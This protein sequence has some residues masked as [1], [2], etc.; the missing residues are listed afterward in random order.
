MLHITSLVLIFTTES[1]YLAPTFIQFPFPQCPTE[2]FWNHAPKGV[3]Y[4]SPIAETTQM[5]INRT[6]HKPAAM[7][8]CIHRKRTLSNKKEQTTYL[9]YNK[10][11]KHANTKEE[12]ERVHRMVLFIRSSRTGKANKWGGHEKSV[13]LSQGW[14][15]GVRTTRKGVWGNFLESEKYS[16]SSL[17]NDT[18]G[19]YICQNSSDCTLKF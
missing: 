11:Q 4:N 15:Q 12:T 3:M 18:V 5:A 9:H 6:K 1:F 16:L 10:T 19:V 14:E 7:P 17:N 8:R 13:S 2:D